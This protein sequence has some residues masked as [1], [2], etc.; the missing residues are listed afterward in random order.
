M[1]NPYATPIELTSQTEQP[2]VV[3]P[4]NIPTEHTFLLKGRFD[5]YKKDKYLA[6]TDDAAYLYVNPSNCFRFARDGAWGKIVRVGA[7]V[8]LTPNGKSHTFTFA[9]TATSSKQP[10]KRIIDAWLGPPSFED[11]KKKLGGVGGSIVLF[12]WGVLIVLFSLPMAADPANQISAAPLDYVGIITGSFLICGSSLR[13]IKP[14][15]YIFF[16]DAVVF[17]MIAISQFINI[18]NGSS[19]WF[20]LFAGFLLLICLHNLRNY[21]RFKTLRGDEYCYEPLE[22]N[23][24]KT[25]SGIS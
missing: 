2:T 18:A 7:S 3:L 9:G 23:T 11:L 17:L 22:R 1:N 24:T 19:R 21:F 20:F 14:G 12:V 25:S 10:D 13:Q 15:R 4:E 16:I 6:L 8:T 5:G